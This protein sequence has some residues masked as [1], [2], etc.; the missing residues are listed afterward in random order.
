M[1]GNI[2]SSTS[3]LEQSQNSIAKSLNLLSSASRI[4]SA[5]DDAAGLAM[6]SAMAAQLGSVD[7]AMRN[8][9]GGLSVAETAGGALNQVSDSL[10]RMRE[11]AVQAANGSNSASDSQT[12][13]GEI[14]QL[15]QGI[16][17]LAGNTQFNGQ[18]LLNGGFSTQLQV[19]PNAGD[20]KALALG[21]VST[22]ALGI[23]G[24]DVTTADNASNAIQSI[25]TA[26]ATVG[27]MQGTVGAA[28]A[29]LSST[30]AALS[31]NYE[32]LA[33]AKSRISDTNYGNET[34]NLTQSEVRQQTAM[35]ALAMYNA[36]QADVL[37]LISPTK[38][39]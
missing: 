27:T 17:Q 12:L 16:D 38:S 18:I 33:S 24:L 28:Q 25:D 3:G 20:T 36:N 8:V 23:N 11:L 26:I 35:R 6:A 2:T 1:I 14:S 39:K 29:S 19:G 22:N 31:G 10:Q 4:N 30:A 9:S 15:G 7:Q 21:N 13:Q 37:T 32:N 34:S 5:R